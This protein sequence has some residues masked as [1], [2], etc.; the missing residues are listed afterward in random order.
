MT[1]G[2]K[3][4]SVLKESEA[5]PF[6]FIGSGMSIR[7]LGLASWETL[8]KNFATQIDSKP[9]Y[10]EKLRDKAKADLIDT[11]K[12]PEGSSLFSRIA[13][14]IEKEYN[15]I[16]HELPTFENSR[17]K[18]EDVVKKGVT[19]FKLEIAEY[20]KE[21]L[22]HPHNLEEEIDLLKGLSS[23]SIGGIITT[24]Y[25]CFLEQVFPDFNTYVGQN[26][27][28]FS[29]HQSVSEIYKIHGCC[30]KPNTIIINSEDYNEFQRKNTYLA[31]KL[32]TIFVEHPIIFMG[33]SLQDENV[34]S[35]LEAIV[36]CLD[37]DNLDV[38]KSRLIF[39]DWQPS[40]EELELS[41]HSITFQNG[42][43]IDMTKVSVN[44]YSELYEILIQIKSKYP[45]KLIRKIKN[46]IY[47]LTLT[48]DPNE[49]L[50][51]INTS[52]Q[53]ENSDHY[54]YVFGIGA[55]EVGRQGY[56]M[57][58]ANDLYSDIIFND[59]NYINKF[60]VENTIPTL[61]STC[62]N[63][64]P[65]FKYITS[66]EDK[67]PLKFENIAN[68]TFEDF[69]NR[70]LRKLCVN[71]QYHSISEIVLS[72]K[73]SLYRELNC[74]AAL[75][76]NEINIDDL[77]SYLYNLLK[78]DTNCLVGSNKSAIKKLIRI[79]DWLRYKEQ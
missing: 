22:A 75:P 25:D 35:I 67:L 77:H 11:G 6:L 14:L 73:Y 24:N 9:L 32:L 51:A 64:L 36:D 70:S 2:E 15:E 63:N 4:L 3:L 54:E 46:D 41:S 10:Y 79:Y 38:L 42:K 12:K 20:C 1:S 76:K 61:M 55:L 58:T 21:T 30:S 52:A 28:I 5:L 60:I 49:R 7:Y 29:N 69:S 66:Y 34:R 48:T 26:E 39:V 74:I 53:N 62:S 18:N 23:H 78:N 17:I 47:Y 65:V 56:G 44:N 59:K 57:I 16:W 19:P 50:V 68:L 72:G 31:A 27:L 37:S 33:Y 40:C 43:T 71:R 8:L 45:T 13:D